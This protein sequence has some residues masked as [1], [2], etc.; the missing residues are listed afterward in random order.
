[1]KRLYFFILLFFTVSISAQMD[2]EHWF[3]PMGSNFSSQLEENYQSVYLSTRETIPF[4]VEIYSGNQLLGKTLIK[5]TEPGIFSIPR[6]FIIT[7]DN[8]EKMVLLNKGLHLIG[9]KKFFANLRF[10]VKNHAEIVTSKGLAGLGKT[11]YLGMPKMVSGNFNYTASV[12]ATDNNTTITLSGYNPSITFTNDS[13]TSTT[14][15]IILNKG[16]SYIFEINND[17]GTNDQTNGLIGAKIESDKPISVSNGNFSG[18]IGST[19]IDIFMD[20]SIDVERT[21]KKFIVM[22]GNGEFNTPDGILMENALVIATTDDTFVYI[23][24]DSAPIIKLN[25][26]EHFFIDGSKYLPIDAPQ[27]IYALHI[28]TSENAYVYQI[29]AGS[30]DRPL[31]SGGMN[32]IP[33]LSCYLPSTIDE[34][35]SIDENPVYDNT[36]FLNNHDVKLNIIAQI[37]ADIYVNNS[38][39]G[40]FGPFPITGTSDWEVYYFPNASGNITVTSK[41]NKA[42]TFGIAGGSSNVGYGG[43]FAGF[44]SVPLITKTG[45]C[46]NGQR[47]EIDDIYDNYEWSYSPDNTPGSFIPYGGNSH[48]IN[49][50]TQ[51]GYYKC[52]VTKNSCGVLPVK[53]FKYLKCPDLSDR[54]F[55][56][57]NCEK[58]PPIKPVFSKNPLI[59]INFS[60]TFISLQPPLSDGIAGIDS[61]GNI[62]FDAN[63]TDKNQVIFKY[64]FEGFGDFPDSEEVTVTVNIE[65]INLRN[66]KIEI[67]SCLKKENGT[68]NLKEFETINQDVSISKFEYYKDISLAPNQEITN[69]YEIENYLSEPEKIIYVKILNS[70]G[71]FKKGEI[72]LKTFELPIITLIETNGLITINVEKGNPPYKYYILKNAPENYSPPIN[73]YQDSK[74]FKITEKGVYTAYVKSS[75]ILGENCDPVAKKFSFVKIHNVITPNDD[76][77]NDTLDSSEL[78]YTTNPKFQIFDRFGTKVFEGNTANNFIWTG[79]SN[80]SPL[81]SSTYWYFIQWSDPGSDAINNLNGWILLKNRN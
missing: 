22:N 11:F 44:S 60:K 33:A 8:S 6:N 24:N 64:Y 53:E 36:G 28:A 15:T 67:I 35:S 17:I 81:P 27:N 23:N 51:F 46:A 61:A 50:G 52:V 48:F 56:I 57:R 3:A 45:D 74:F 73:L 43:Y 41:N 29:L 58:I 38:K 63:G 59:P 16:E 69:S 55:T 20:Q 12:I 9:A 19:G 26:G 37:G 34:L 76:G 32:L 70:S 80:G 77:K 13:T 7:E 62:T 68:Y 1:M 39:I 75:D 71:C 2:V 4:E 14:K 49:P 72:S 31:P 40:L 18:R 30:S 25:K 66:E 65:Q 5:N 42:V 54:S 47:L 21:G 10:S 78:Q 79:K